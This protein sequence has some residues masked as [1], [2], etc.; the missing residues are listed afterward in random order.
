MLQIISL[1]YKVC[2]LSSL[3][4]TFASSEQAVLD[5]PLQVDESFHLLGLVAAMVWF[6]NVI[7]DIYAQICL[8]Y[9]YLGRLVH[10]GR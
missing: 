3:S 2:V 1:E 4:I 8:G 5:G 9:I 6:H 10:Q 7:H